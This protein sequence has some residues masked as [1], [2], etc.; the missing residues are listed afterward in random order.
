MRTRKEIA[1]RLAAHRTR[2]AGEF[3]VQSLAVF[4]SA[5]RDELSPES[6]VD[7]LAEFRPEA[8]AGLFELVALREYLEGL[9]GCSVDVVTADGLRAW[10]RERVVWEAVRVV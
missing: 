10:M 1:D 3:G 5:A 4:G 8:H 6:D 2:L 9:L 7:V